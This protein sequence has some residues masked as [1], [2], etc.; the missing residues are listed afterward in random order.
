MIFSSSEKVGQTGSLPSL[1]E[2]PHRRKQGKAASLP[3]HRA[4]IFIVSGRRRSDMNDSC[5][6][7][8]TS[9]QLVEGLVSRPQPEASTSWKLVGH[10]ASRLSLFQG[11]ETGMKDSSEKGRANCQFALPSRRDI[12]CSRA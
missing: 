2:R 5:G 11:V 12:Q 3:Y 6:K 8:P 4:A 9:F 1:P 10:C 7:C